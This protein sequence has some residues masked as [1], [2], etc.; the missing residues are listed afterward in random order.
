MHFIFYFNNSYIY[1]KKTFNFIKK[2]YKIIK[3]NLLT[4]PSILFFAFLF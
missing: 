3:I 2:I 4:Q 1:L